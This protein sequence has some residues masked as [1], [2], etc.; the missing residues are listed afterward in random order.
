LARNHDFSELRVLLVDDNYFMV[1]LLTHLMH[2]MGVR[3]I[4]TAL[5]GESA[6]DVFEDYAPGLIVSDWDMK[7]V[8]GEQLVRMVRDRDLSPDPYVPII[9]LTGYSEIRRV[10]AARDFGVTEFLVKPISAA[11]LYQRLVNVVE[12]PRP[13]VD[14]EQYFGP[15]RRRDIADDFAGAERRSV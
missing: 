11:R 3:H 2:A 6:F 1:Q 10:I 5:D 12:R 8:N 4:A 14:A 9:M 13:F 7:P 15:C